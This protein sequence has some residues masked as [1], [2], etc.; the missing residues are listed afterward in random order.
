MNQQLIK[1]TSN[2]LA[3]MIASLTI[4]TVLMVLCIPTSALLSFYYSWQLQIILFIAIA[5]LTYKSSETLFVGLLGAFYLAPIASYIYF[6]VTNGAFLIFLSLGI[7]TLIFGLNY[8][9][10][11]NIVNDTQKTLKFEQLVSGYG[12]TVISSFLI[13]ATAVFILH[14]ITPLMP[15]AQLIYSS[16]IIWYSS[17]LLILRTGSLLSTDNNSTLNDQ[18]IELYSL[19]YAL[20][21][22]FDLLDILIQ[23]LA[24]FASADKSSKPK[25][26]LEFVILII[27]SPFII[28]YS[29]W[30]YATH[31]DNSL[32]HHNTI[33]MQPPV[34]P[35]PPL[36]THKDNSTPRPPISTP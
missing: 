3:Q 14:F 24:I 21:L 36:L 16:A 5:T 17:L 23:I 25:I 18:E 13:V 30:I 27:T 7:T 10:M 2:K 9:V 1:K 12:K 35:T 26:P 6:Y 19:H 32:N 20:G 15:I 4:A 34:N 28:I 33:L 22:F 11:Q 31:K 8:I 29:V